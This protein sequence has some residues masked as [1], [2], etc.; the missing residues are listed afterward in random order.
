MS[1]QSASSDSPPPPKKRIITLGPKGAR[2]AFE[3]YLDLKKL[4]FR[5]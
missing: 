1:K 5:K 4:G 3:Y 2:A